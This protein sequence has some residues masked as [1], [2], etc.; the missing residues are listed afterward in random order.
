MEHEALTMVSRELPIIIR[1]SI[2][3]PPEDFEGGRGLETT[4]EKTGKASSEESSIDPHNRECKIRS[5]RND[6]T[7]R[8][9]L[10]SVLYISEIIAHHHCDYPYCPHNTNTNTTN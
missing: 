1:C 10:L 7:F 2:S 5:L 3:N 4:H 8:V 6:Y 9:T